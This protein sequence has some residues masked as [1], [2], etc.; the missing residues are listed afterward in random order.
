[1][2]KAG[3]KLVI[4]YGVFDYDVADIMGY[5]DHAAAVGMKVIWD[6]SSRPYRDG[7]FDRD[8]IRERVE[9]VKT[10]PATWGYCIA[11]EP[12][13]NKHR[14]V[15]SLSDYVHNLDP[16]HPRF[17]V[18][19][20]QSNDPT[21]LLRPHVDAAD[22]IALDVYTTAAGDP[23]PEDVGPVAKAGQELA[24]KTDKKC[25]IVLQSFDAKPY[26]DDGRLPKE[27]C[28]PGWPSRERMIEERNLAL[29][30][31]HPVFILWYSYFDILKS[32]DPVGHWAD[33]VAAGF[34]NKR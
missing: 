5:A 18:H 14:Q 27:D 21:V 34:S 30:N 2:A 31:S 12:D 4:N 19:Y 1:M 8:Y 20:Y 23:T 13:E 16:A 3:F 32:S 7:T 29:E 22:V 25:A 26:I 33:L 10:H 11:D 17:L 15:K 6:M 9:A 24:D 28:R